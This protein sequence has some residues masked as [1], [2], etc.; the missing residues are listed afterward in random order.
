MNTPCTS[1][2]ARV[3]TTA[4]H[5]LPPW[6]SHSSDWFVIS[7]THGHLDGLKALLARRNSG[8][9]L[10]HLGDIGDRG[11]DTAGVYRLLDSIDDEVLLQ[12]NH[13]LMLRYSLIDPPAS[14]QCCVQELWSLNGNETTVASIR[15]DLQSSGIPPKAPLQVPDYIKRVIRRQRK[16]QLDGSL[17]FVH[18][19]VNPIV[20]A[21]TLAMS[22][23][24]GVDTTA[25]HS[26][27]Q[28][29]TWIMDPFLNRSPFPMYLHGRRLFVIHGHA[30]A[31]APDA[32]DRDDSLD[33]DLQDGMMAIEICG[34]R[35]RRHWIDG[36]SDC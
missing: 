8:E 14:D 1:S 30:Q 6:I 20:P 18:A 5:D 2:S 24:Q 27:D 25:L 36:E 31:P 11:P 16:F 22:P 35:W 10:I 7:D 17:L 32:L 4:W 12:G 15:D 26:I 33:C 13:D 3:L 29:Y 21:M 19:G 34:R 9:R 28:H 23:R